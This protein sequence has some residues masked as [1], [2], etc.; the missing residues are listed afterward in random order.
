MDAINAVPALNDEIL[1]LN[2]MYT[3]GVVSSLQN[4]LS[5]V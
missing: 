4:R 2:H 5:I 3:D 1:T